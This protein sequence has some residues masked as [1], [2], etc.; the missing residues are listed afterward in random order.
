MYNGSVVYLPNKYCLI[1]S[2]II[3]NITGYKFTQLL[4]Q[5]HIEIAQSLLV[6]TNMAISNIT[7]HIGYDTPE[8]FIRTFKKIIRMTPTQFRKKAH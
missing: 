6:D 5:I 7:S 1:S 8:H 2:K 4:Q 3:K